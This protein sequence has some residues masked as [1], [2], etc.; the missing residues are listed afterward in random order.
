MPVVG[1]ASQTQVILDSAEVTIE[2]GDGYFAQGNYGAAV[3]AYQTAGG[4]LALL[5]GGAI[6]AAATLRTQSATGASGSEA[7]QS[8]DLAR[9]VLASAAA[10]NPSPTVVAE[11]ASK[12][13]TVVDAACALALL[14][15]LGYLVWRRKR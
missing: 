10:A 14:V 3:S 7:A 1:T 6:P 15:G 8:G 4:Q 5:P 9:A 11:G 12:M 2:S 13:S